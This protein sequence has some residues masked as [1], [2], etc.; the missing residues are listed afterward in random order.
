VMALASR[1]SSSAVPCAIQV[2]VPVPM[3][4]AP[5]YTSTRPSSRLRV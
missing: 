5:F 3:S 1:P 4:W 2:R